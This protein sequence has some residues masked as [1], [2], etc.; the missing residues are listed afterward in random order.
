MCFAT[1]KSY[2]LSGGLDRR[3]NLFRCDSGDFSLVK[4]WKVA[5]QVLSISMSPD[6]NTMVYGM[7]NLLSIYQ[8]KTDKE[9][10][11]GK[12]VNGD[13]FGEKK[14]KRKR[15]NSTNNTPLYIDVNSTNQIRRRAA[16]PVIQRE[17]TSFGSITEPI[18][19]ELTAK[20]LDKVYF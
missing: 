12:N 11:D 4:S 7:T 17:Q 9:L 14:K 13:F 3:I 6:D 19:V 16:P 2:L 20:S 15:S 5:A 18:R 1:N 8:R 10:H